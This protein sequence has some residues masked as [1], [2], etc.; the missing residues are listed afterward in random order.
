[1]IALWLAEH[2]RSEEEQ[3]TW[4]VNAV[5]KRVLQHHEYLPECV[6]KAHL[7]A[8]DKVYGSSAEDNTQMLNVGSFVRRR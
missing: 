3:V 6:Y 7:D 4:S 1:M 2:G 8:W 5:T